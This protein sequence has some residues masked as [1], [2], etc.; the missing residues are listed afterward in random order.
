MSR[1]STADVA[2]IGGGVIGAVC[3]RAAAE[4]GLHTAVF[5]PGPDPAAASAASASG[6]ETI[7]SPWPPR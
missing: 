7:T 6:R 5:E 3:A 4:R 2:I 1:V